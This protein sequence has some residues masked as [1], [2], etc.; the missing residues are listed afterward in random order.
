M[1][2]NGV[3]R[4][5][6]TMGNYEGTMQESGTLQ[7]RSVATIQPR[8]IRLLQGEVTRTWKESNLEAEQINLCVVKIIKQWAQPV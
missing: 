1:N 8:A 3:D 4:T 6:S 7:G 2:Y 5:L